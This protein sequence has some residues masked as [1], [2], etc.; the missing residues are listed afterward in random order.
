AD[1]PV[2]PRPHLV[3]DTRTY[4]R[5]GV[6]GDPTKASRE[7]GEKMVEILSR[8]LAKLAESMNN[9]EKKGIKSR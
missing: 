5:S 3:R 9:R 6:W 4:W 8:N 1:R 2:F 7:K